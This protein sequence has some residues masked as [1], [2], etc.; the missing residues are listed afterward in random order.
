MAHLHYV[1]IGGMVFPVFAAVYYWA[2]VVSGRQLS[3]R[4]GKWACGL[5]FAVSRD[6]FSHAHFRHGWHATAR[7]DVFGVDGLGPV[8]HDLHAGA[9]VLAAGVLLVLIDLVL[10]LRMAEKV[11]VN[12]WRAGTLDWLP[13]DNYAARS[14]PQ[15]DS[16][17]PLWDQ[18][19]L[20]EEVDSGQH[21]LPGTMTGTR[22][23][24]VTSAMTAS[25]EYLLRLP[26]PS[27]LPM[28]GG[29]ATAVFFFALTLKFT[30]IAVA[31]AAVALGSILCWLWEGDPAPSG[32]R[33]AVGEAS[34]CQTNVGS[35]LNMA[36]GACAYCLS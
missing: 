26:G 28:L 6:V 18:P 12:P 9:F 2:P 10:H 33:H 35:A 27:W 8:E 16:R 13:L 21:Y 3:E 22:E 30:W 24:I 15:I 36:G 5:M 29:L 23:T 17:Y 11:D 25:P 32:K 34:S 1:L 7:L 14:I 20:R 19:G 4:I 31:S